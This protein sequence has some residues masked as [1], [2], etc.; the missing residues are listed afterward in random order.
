[1]GEILSALLM[2]L[3]VWEKKRKFS[4]AILMAVVASESSHPGRPSADFGSPKSDFFLVMVSL[5][6]GFFCVNS[7]L[8]ME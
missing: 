2:L 3:H 8:Y 1:M 7:Q 5:G 6:V 4:L